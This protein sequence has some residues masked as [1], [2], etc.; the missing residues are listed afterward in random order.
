MHE[1]SGGTEKAAVTRRY[2]LL[3]LLLLVDVQLSEMC[4]TVPPVA[5][6]S[7]LQRGADGRTQCAAR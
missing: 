6:P 2:L 4:G 7:K 1:R 3:L 5:G